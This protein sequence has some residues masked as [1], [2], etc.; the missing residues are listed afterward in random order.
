MTVYTLRGGEGEGDEAFHCKSVEV[1]VVGV[2]LQEKDW[3]G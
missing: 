1:Q 2:Q 3:D